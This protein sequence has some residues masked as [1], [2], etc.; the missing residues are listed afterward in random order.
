MYPDLFRT[1]LRGRESRVP[2]AGP[3][4]AV[5]QLFVERDTRRFHSWS[6]GF[7]KPPW[8]RAVRLDSRKL[9]GPMLGIR[10]HR[11]VVKSVFGTL[12]SSASLAAW[13][14]CSGGATIKRETEEP[15]RQRRLTV[16]RSASLSE[17][18]SF[19][20]TLYQTPPANIPPKLSRVR[21]HQYTV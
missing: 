9:G 19:E 1:L 4:N 18:I 5:H 7:M 6:S 20:Y 21:P 13:P 15:P 2:A 16:W 8:R 12:T 11:T 3:R 10:L 14:A 17:G